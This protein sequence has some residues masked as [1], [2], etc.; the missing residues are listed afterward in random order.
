L[1]IRQAA[2]VG[3]VFFIGAFQSFESLKVISNKL[4]A[5]GDFDSL[6][7]DNAMVFKYLLGSAGLVFSFLASAIYFGWLE[8]LGL[9]LKR[10]YTNGITF[11]I[12]VRVIERDLK[13]VLGLIFS[14]IIAAV[15]RIRYLNNPI[16]H[17]E[18]YSFIVFASTTLINIISNYHLPNNHVFHTLLVNLST[19]LFGIQPWAVRLPSFL[20]GLTL[21]PASYVLA[22]KIYDSRIALVTALLVAVL[23]GPISYGTISR[24][25]S[26]VA[27]FTILILWLAI[28][29]YEEKN[30]FA[31]LLLILFAAL[32]FY[33]VPVMLYSF[34][35]VYAWLFIQNLII[36]ARQYNSKFEFTKF[37]LCGGLGTAV[38]VLLLYTPIFIYSGT[39]KV[40]ANKWVSPKTWNSFI[41]TN[42]IQFV[43]TWK[44][45]FFG[46][47][48]IVPV[49]AA[50]G[51]ILSILLNGRLTR[52]RFPLQLAA[53]GW[54][55][56]LL[57]IQRAIIGPKIFV[58]L[59]VPFIMW[60][61]AGIL[62]LLYELN[63]IFP[64]KVSLPTLFV[65]C[66]LFYVLSSGLNAIKST[67]L[68][69]SEKGPTEQAILFIQEQYADQ[70][71]VIIDTPYDASAWYYA[72][73][74]GLPD[75]LFNKDMPFSRLW[76]IVSPTYEQTLLSV[77]RARGP[78]ESLINIDRASLIW[79]KGN[80]D[81]Y[82]VQHR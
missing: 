48:A 76:V 57:L 71:L 34:G 72:R 54:I 38:L 3:L 30:E 52:Y 11:F 66:I 33:S 80:I 79:S 24:G 61:V 60:A 12:R 31:W 41:R 36:K 64:L 55:L 37:W 78:D 23:P 49:L 7:K 77:I 4:V 44:E 8:G 68:S 15:M 27:F 39:D 42:P 26:L 43:D 13:F 40:F 35:I 67:P 53:F 17:D 63:R 16:S 45:W 75:S 50:A 19:N 56:A 73:L 10:I 47:S 6:K 58:F 32:G 59:Q 28:Y 46:E 82:E 70:D 18:A 20:A 65:I 14:I 62:G 22:K 5:D 69:W 81:I 74:Y 25:Y 2:L 29:V 51:F 1:K 21:V 9:G